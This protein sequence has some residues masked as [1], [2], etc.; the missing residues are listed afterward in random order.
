MQVFNMVRRSPAENLRTGAQHAGTEE[1]ML[2][3]RTGRNP[4]RT[5]V[6]IR[7]L[8]LADGV[9]MRKKDEISGLRTQTIN[10]RFAIKGLNRISAN[11]EMSTT[12]LL[13]QGL[14][15]IYHRQILGLG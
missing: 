4:I 10:L 11:Q 14:A 9:R 15:E 7:E 5:I 8:V 3:I 2:A 6:I 13:V 12:Y 1:P